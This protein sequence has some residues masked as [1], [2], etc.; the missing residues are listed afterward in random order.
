[1]THAS[2]DTL[3]LLLGRRSHPAVS[4]RAPAPD[5]EDLTRILTAAA[6]VP[7]HGKLAPWRF[8]LIRGSARETLGERLVALLEARDGPL[9]DDRRAQELGRFARAP[10]V[11]AVVSKAAVHPK[12]PVWEQQLSVGAVCMNLVIAA[13]ASGF[14]AQWLTEWMAYD[15]EAA[16]LLGLAETERVA[17]FIHIGTPS[18]A[19]GERPRPDLDSIV[20]DWTGA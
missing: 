10:L 11:V 1:M 13:H 4:L 7:D 8:V 16:A 15:D 17:G 19:P 5:G 2:P 9:P 18:E 14:A 3:R 6:R 12:I 20:S